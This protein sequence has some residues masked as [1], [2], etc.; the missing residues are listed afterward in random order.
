MDV[1]LG[2][3]AAAVFKTSQGISR[4]LAE[5]RCRARRRVLSVGWGEVFGLIGPNRGK[6]TLVKILLSICGGSQGRVMR[7][8]HSISSGARWPASATFTRTPLFHAT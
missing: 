7:L 1:R 3:R 2:V 4:R 8:E 6:T 5:T